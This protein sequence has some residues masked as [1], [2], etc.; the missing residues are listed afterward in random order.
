MLFIP[1]NELFIVR[2]KEFPPSRHS[3]KCEMIS[4]HR[5]TYRHTDRQAQTG[6]HTQAGTHRQAHTGR[7]KQTNRQTDKQ[8][9]RQTDKQTQADRQT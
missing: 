4:T 3:V 5:H 7:H 6:R 2:L 1:P 9:N 8:T